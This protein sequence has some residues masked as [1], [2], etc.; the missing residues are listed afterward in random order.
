MILIPPERAQP[1]KV[2]E[3]RTGRNRLVDPAGECTQRVYRDG[4]HALH[5]PIVAEPQ[6]QQ[7]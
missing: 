7:Q 3:A 2:H 5:L 4:T 1:T 6:M